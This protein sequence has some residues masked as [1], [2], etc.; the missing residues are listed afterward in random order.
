MSLLNDGRSRSRALI[1]S[2]SLLFGVLEDPRGAA[3]GSFT[4]GENLNRSFSR[5]YTTTTTRYVVGQTE[6][7]IE[8]PKIVKDVFARDA[9]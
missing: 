8:N 9:A 5:Y 7:W 1:K 4:I 6:A 3:S 2:I